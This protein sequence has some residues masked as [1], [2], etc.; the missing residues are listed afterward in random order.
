MK[1]SFPFVTRKFTQ[2]IFYYTTLVSL[3]FEAMKV[4]KK[5]FILTLMGLHRC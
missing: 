2:N 4:C 1:H 3:S 5:I